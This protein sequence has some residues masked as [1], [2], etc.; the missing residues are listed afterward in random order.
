[1]TQAIVIHSEIAVL[2][3]RLEELRQESAKLYL[4][5]EYMQFEERPHLL[6]L[7]ETHIGKLL[8][9][10]FQLNVEI[11]LVNLE[12]QLFQAYIN[13]NERPDEE[14]IAHRISL[15]KAKFKDELEEKEA[16]IKAAQDYL[17]APSYSKEETEELRDLY[18]MIAKALHPDLHPEQTQKERDMFL[19]A[20]SAYRIG[21]IFV[22]RQIALALTE[23]SIVDIP[24]TDL[25]RLIEKA[26]ETVNS[27]KHRIEQMN[28]VFPFIYR[29]NLTN[30]DWI[31]EQQVEIAER[32]ATAKKQLEQTMNYLMMLK[33][34]K[35]DS[36]S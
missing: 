33:I 2:Q 15:E 4:R 3:N 17:N 36:L 6:S 20:V 11:R 14:Q 28:S 32:I 5:A 13:R 27:F 9:E 1:M 18:R 29:D 35:P 10:E 22:L 12:A 25:P 16:S 23:E 24:E 34:W 19:K 21:D 26:Q 7:Y 8:F 31:K 30:A